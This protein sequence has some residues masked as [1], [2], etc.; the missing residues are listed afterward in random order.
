MNSRV[1][2]TCIV[3]VKVRHVHSGKEIQTYA[4]LDCCSKGTFICTDLARKLKADGIKTTIKIKTL[5][6]EDT[7]ESEAISGLKVSKS[8]GKPVWIDLP[9]IYAKT[10]LPVG[11]ED[12]VAPNKIKEWEYL[13]KIADEITQTENISIGILIGGNCSRALEPREV[14]P[15]KNGGPYAFQTLL[16]WC[17]VGPVGAGGN[18]ASVACNRVA[19]QDLTSK[20]IAPHYFPTETEIKDIGIEQMLHKMYLADFIDQSSSV[21]QESDCEMLVEDRR[22][23]EIMNRECARE[24]KH[25]LP[26]PLKDQDQDFPINR[27]MAELRL[28]NLK[29]RFKHDKKFHE[30]YTN[31]MQDMIKVMLKFK[32]RRN[33]NKV[34]FGTFLTMLCFT[35][36]GQEK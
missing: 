2:S 15:S 28:H 16:G 22:F 7:Q 4:M 13:E 30:V 11:D 35:Q 5:N 34:K 12:V 29:K 6:G 19:V 33:V 3:P 21:L 26:L 25:K 18:D 36:A 27:K 9:V 8:I 24:G 23:M 31:F 14:I 1:V 10:D 32:M 20:A 17:I